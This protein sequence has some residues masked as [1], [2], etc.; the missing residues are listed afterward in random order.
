MGKHEGLPLYPLGDNIGLVSLVDT[1]KEDIPLKVINSARI[2]YNKRKNTFKDSDQ[3][4]TKY[5]WNHEHTSP[6]RHSYYTFHC[7]CPLF[8]FRQWIKYQVGSTWR[9]Y[10]VDHDNVSIEIF[11]YLYDTD[12]GCSWN[13]ISGRYVELKPEFYIP[14]KFRTNTGHANKQ[15]SGDIEWDDARHETV[16]NTWR[17]RSER[18]FQEYKEYLEMGIAKELARSM[19]PQN[20]YTQAYWT[21]SLQAILH[22]LHQR[23]KLDAQYEIRMYAESIYELLKNDLDRVGISR[24][25][26][27]NL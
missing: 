27:L 8:V 7:K 18:A 1:M 5:L 25:S 22:F 23:L 19:L 26:L 2:S 16:Y 24:E 6:F 4:L 10:F 9:G 17:Y 12:K 11:D 14:K 3:S 21:A 15:A 13:E 20:I